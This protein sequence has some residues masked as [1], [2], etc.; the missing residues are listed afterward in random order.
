VSVRHLHD[1]AGQRPG[2]GAAG[3][4][5]AQTLAPAAMARWTAQSQSIQT[6]PLAMARRLPPAPLPWKAGSGEPDDADPP[7]PHPSGPDRF[8]SVGL[9][10]PLRDEG[11]FH[12]LYLISLR[13][14]LRAGRGPRLDQ[15][16]Q[17][18]PRPAG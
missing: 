2:P 8:V 16:D 12:E 13:P 5:P 3:P 4:G 10:V 11:L 7:G 18:A 9:T 17:P 14:G 6:G 1:Q 15:R